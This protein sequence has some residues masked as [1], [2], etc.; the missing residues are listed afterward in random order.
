MLQ[1]VTNAHHCGVNGMK[2]SAIVRVPIPKPARI[3]IK[4]VTGVR[5]ITLLPFANG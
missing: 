1:T 5:V 3:A 2:P 4:R